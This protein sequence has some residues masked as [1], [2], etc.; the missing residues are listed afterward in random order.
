MRKEAISSL[1]LLISMYTV[2]AA[3]TL[4][5]Q[6]WSLFISG[7]RTFRLWH[8]STMPHNDDLPG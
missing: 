1:A 2:V 5:M 4:W 8:H 3:L 6:P 7:M